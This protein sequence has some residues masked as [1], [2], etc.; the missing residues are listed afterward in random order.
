MIFCYFHTEK[1][2]PHFHKKI[3]CFPPHTPKEKLSKL[4][5]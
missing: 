2:F 4:Q 3:L 1:E 5:V